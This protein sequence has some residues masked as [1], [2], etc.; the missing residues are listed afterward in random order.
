ME[1]PVVSYLLIVRSENLIDF[2]QP[3]RG[4][5][6]LLNVPLQD[7]DQEF[8]QIRCLRFGPTHLG[9]GVYGRAKHARSE[10]ARLGGKLRGSEALVVGAHQS[11]GE[12]VEV[13]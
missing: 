3:P 12:S 2:L 5:Q 8:A 13:G 11:V 10:K 6:P 1:R 7:L 4:D 9:K